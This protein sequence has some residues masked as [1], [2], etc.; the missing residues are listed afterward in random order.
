MR[1]SNPVFSRRGFSRDNGYAQFNANAQA[2]QAA[3]SSQRAA[4]FTLNSLLKL[5]AFLFAA[6]ALISVTGIALFVSMDWLSRKALGHW[7][8]SA[9]G[10]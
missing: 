6:L 4:G 9:Q 2:P 1:S 10:A 7:H 3:S 8:E 5:G